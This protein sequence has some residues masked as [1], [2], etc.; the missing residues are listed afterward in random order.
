MRRE[1]ALKQQE[2]EFAKNRLFKWN[3]AVLF[4]TIIVVLFAVQTRQPDLPNLKLAQVRPG[5]LD[6][7]VKEWHAAKLW[8]YKPTVEVEE[9]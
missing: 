6:Q 2:V 8:D 1:L 7:I 5:L 3:Y 9:K 4:M